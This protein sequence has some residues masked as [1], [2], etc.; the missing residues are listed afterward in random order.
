MCYT[1]EVIITTGIFERKVNF[2][3]QKSSQ[4]EI[5]MSWR[6]LVYS[7]WNK[8][9]KRVTIFLLR[10]MVTLRIIENFSFGLEVSLHWVGYYVLKYFKAVLLKKKNLY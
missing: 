9:S 7:L 8:P 1:R 4:N 6:A 5:Q 10:L 2:P 3:N